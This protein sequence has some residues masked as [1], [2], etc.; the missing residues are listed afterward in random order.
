MKRSSLCIKATENEEVAP[1][2]AGFS[3]NLSC[4]RHVHNQK[5]ICFLKQFTEGNRQVVKGVYS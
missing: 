4:F 2:G 3:P 5:V 1:P